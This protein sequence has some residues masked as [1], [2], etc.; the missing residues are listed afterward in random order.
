MFS[1]THL[2]S[3]AFLGDTA[4]GLHGRGL[5]LLGNSDRFC[6]RTAVTQT[7]CWTSGRNCS[8]LPLSV[9]VSQVLCNVCVRLQ[10]Q[11]GQRHVHTFTSVVAVVRCAFSA[12]F[13][14]WIPGCEPWGRGQ[15]PE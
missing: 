2:S 8:S 11:L 5:S 1:V 3:A 10:P 4:S 9:L 15:C 7:L 13:C 14:F 12:E 6:A